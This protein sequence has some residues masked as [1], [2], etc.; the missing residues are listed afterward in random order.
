MAEAKKQGK[1]TTYKIITIVLVLMT[2]ATIWFTQFRETKAL[3]D[4]PFY[5]SL[6]KIIVN[7]ESDNPRHY[8]KVEPVLVTRNIELSENIEKFKPILRSHLIEILRKESVATLS[9]P[10]SFETIRDRNL[11]DLN[12]MLQSKTGIRGLDDLLFNEFVVQ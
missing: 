11:K 12:R 8:L 6:D 9:A 10:N 1:G 5:F 2:A 4:D 3:T 7:L